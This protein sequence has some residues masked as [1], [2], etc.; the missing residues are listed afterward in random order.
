MQH[1][2][3]VLLY[4]IALAFFQKYPFFKFV[5]TFDCVLLLLVVVVGFFLFFFF[6]FSSINFCYTET[7]VVSLSKV[8]RFVG[9]IDLL[10]LLIP[11]KLNCKNNV[12]VRYVQIILIN[13]INI[14]LEEKL[15]RYMKS[16]RLS[17]AGWWLTHCRNNILHRTNAR[18]KQNRIEKNIF[19]AIRKD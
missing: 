15:R 11:N 5:D 16:S 12:G 10:I 13:L 1:N 6:K 19:A 4:F 9:Y 3:Y 2:V 17:S 18:N 8:R 7:N 14:P